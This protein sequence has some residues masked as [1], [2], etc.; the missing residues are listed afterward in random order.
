MVSSI[1]K[2]GSKAKDTFHNIKTGAK[3]MIKAAGDKIKDGA[4]WLSEKLVMF[5]TILKIQVS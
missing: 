2:F 3:D 4:S 5:G 1:G